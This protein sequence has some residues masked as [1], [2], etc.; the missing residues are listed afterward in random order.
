M[1]SIEQKKDIILLAGFSTPEA[2]FPLLLLLPLHLFDG[3]RE[4][5]YDLLCLLLFG[6]EGMAGAT[7]V[8]ERILDTLIGSAIAFGAN[9]FILPVWEAR[10]IPGALAEALIANT[11]Y[12]KRAVEYPNH[13]QTVD[14]DFVGSPKIKTVCRMSKNVCE[15]NKG[16]MQTA[17]IVVR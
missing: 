5:V 8:R 2:S 10:F 12:L 14:S 16:F 3:F 1:S 15:P 4:S 11:N 13:H 9:Y 17:E 6:L 7:L